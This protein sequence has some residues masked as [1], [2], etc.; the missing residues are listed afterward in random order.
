MHWPTVTETLIQHSNVSVLRWDKN[1]DLI[2]GNKLEKLAW[3]QSLIQAHQPQWVFSMGGPWSNHLHALGAELQHQSSHG[4]VFIR[5]EKPLKPSPTLRDLNQWGISQHF[6][7]RSDYR[8][9]RLYSQEHFKDCSN[10][11]TTSGLQ[12]SEP[13]NLPKLNAISQSFNK[14]QSQQLLQ[15]IN[16][17]IDRSK[18]F[19]PQVISKAGL[20]SSFTLDCNSS[21]WIPEGGDNAISLWSVAAWAKELCEQ[22]SKKGDNTDAWVI[23][24]GSGATYKGILAGAYLAQTNQPKHI[25]GVPVFSSS[26][27]FDKEIEAF[28]DHWFGEPTKK[29]QTQAPTRQWQL[30][31]NQHW[32]GFAK[33][34]QPLANQHQNLEALFQAPLDRVYTLKTAYALMNYLNQSTSP[35]STENDLDKS[36]IQSWLLFHTGGLQGNRSL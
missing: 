31:H 8:K 19:I 26:E 7:S 11:H 21:W 6:V 12:S 3:H 5:G 14:P 29:N 32:G 10:R 34:P 2:S 20:E 1:H 22:L 15:E 23:P 4:Y 16:L 25:I 30:W 36:K 28:I 35:Q 17:T 9:L 13:P 27:Y 24:M 33:Y 18:T